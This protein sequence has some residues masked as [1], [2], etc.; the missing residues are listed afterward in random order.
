MCDS[1]AQ[2]THTDECLLEVLS[3][4]DEVHLDQWYKWRMRDGRVHSIDIDEE[5]VE[6]SFSDPRWLRYVLVSYSSVFR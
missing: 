4:L 3:M 1:T 2:K 6:E 5:E